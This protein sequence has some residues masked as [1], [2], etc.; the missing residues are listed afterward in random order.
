MN[1]DRK[2]LFRFPW[3]A[4]DNPGAWIEV[5]DIC[6]LNCPGCFRKNN[7]TG[8]RPL[9]E[10][11]QEVLQCRDQLNCS[12]IC[13]SGGEPLLYPDI[14]ET[15]RYISSL[16]MKPIILSNGENL[17][18]ELLRQ[19]RN[20]GLYQFY[21]H[22]DSGQER[23]GWTGK[24]EEEMNELRQRLTDMVHKAG[25]IRCGFNL[26]VRRSNL[27][28]ISD[29]VRWFRANVHKVNSLSLITYRGIPDDPTCEMLVNGHKIDRQIIAS[30]IRPESEINITTIDLHD[31]LSRHFDS[32][33][34]TAYL[35][36][37]P[38]EDTFKYLV[39][40]NAGSKNRIYGTVGPKTAEIY[41]L[42]YHVF[43]G[44]YDAVIP[45]PGRAIFFM[46]MFDKKL[47]STLKKYLA[48]VLRNP[49]R[50]FEGIH[51]QALILQQ[52][53]EVIDGRPNLCDGC[54]NL[55]P[56]QGKLINSCRYD[57]YRILGGPITFV[58]QNQPVH[59]HE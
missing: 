27:G 48:A 51:I 32:L 55:M 40:I 11:K 45:D 38:A 46:A 23:P 52:P 47:R 29:I 5:T 3:S 18:P 43:T 56:W 19:L 42:L 59:P 1:F 9:E 10:I 22:A 41:Q 36:G 4:T 15:V 39:T 49:L 57:E 16:K 17:T 35:N 13:I 26:T 20:A 21:F 24:T 54:I 30:N 37:T 7:L 12:R 44:R 14:L 25:K 6:N 28:Q 33:H 34:P 2:D 50:L 53:F 31:E 58:K 8:H